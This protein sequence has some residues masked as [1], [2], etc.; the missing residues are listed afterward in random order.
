MGWG[1]NEFAHRD[2]R[3]GPPRPPATRSVVRGVEL[4][5]D[6]GPRVA[7]ALDLRQAVVEHEIRDAGCRR[8]FRLQDVGLARKQHALRAQA[9]I[10]LIGGRLGGG[11]EACVGDPPRLRDIGRE[12]DCRENVKVVRTSSSQHRKPMAMPS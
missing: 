7:R 1:S 5:L 3:G 2:G 4:F 9:G 6:P 10:D 8:N 12:S 11:D